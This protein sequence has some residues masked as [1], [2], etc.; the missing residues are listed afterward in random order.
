M[1]TI[2]W[3]L[4]TSSHRI[5]SRIKLGRGG[6]RERGSSN[7]DKG[8]KAGIDG[9]HTNQKRANVIWKNATESRCCMQT[10]R[11]ALGSAKV[12]GKVAQKV[13]KK[14]LASTIKL[15]ILAERTV[16]LETFGAAEGA[17]GFDEELTVCGNASVVSEPC[18]F[19]T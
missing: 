6:W 8:I 11:D 1:A 5:P 7:I 2:R 10:S 17:G 13:L 16:N 14:V 19:S 12:E 18:G 3:E 4:N 9:R 15:Q